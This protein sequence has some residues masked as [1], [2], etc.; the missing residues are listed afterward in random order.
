[1]A[2][3]NYGKLTSMHFYGWKLGL[4]TGMY[5]LR[6]KAAAAAIQFT[7]DKTKAAA[8]SKAGEDGDKAGETSAAEGAKEGEAQGLQNM[9]AMVCSL[10][11]KDDCLMCGS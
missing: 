3:P 6:T 9:A 10:Q 7:V 11:N 4:K 1:M 5:Y 8:A 2:E